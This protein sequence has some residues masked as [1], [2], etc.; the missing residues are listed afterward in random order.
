MACEHI[1]AS[2]LVTSLALR[3]KLMARQVAVLR[4]TQMIVFNSGR[5]NPAELAGGGWKMVKLLPVATGYRTSITTLK[6]HSD[7]CLDLRCHRCGGEVPVG[8]AGDAEEPPLDA[9]QEKEAM[10]A[11]DQDVLVLRVHRA[12]DTVH[13]QVGRGTTVGAAAEGVR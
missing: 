9:L 6:N 11:N 1:E 12:R 5:L 13:W 4:G 7:D 10:R 2:E 8:P 3:M